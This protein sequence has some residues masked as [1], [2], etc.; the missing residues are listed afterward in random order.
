MDA[1]QRRLRPPNGNWEVFAAALS[2]AND[3]SYGTL[4]PH[5]PQPH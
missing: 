1:M 3:S 2:P 5:A 4:S